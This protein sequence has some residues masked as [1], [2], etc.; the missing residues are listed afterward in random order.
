VPLATAL[1]KTLP[2]ENTQRYLS[3][4][5]HTRVAEPYEEEEEE[6]AEEEEAEEEEEEEEEEE[7]AAA[8][9]AQ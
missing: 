8:R 7:A 4:P 2:T 6:E 3:R 1:C 5:K 9:T